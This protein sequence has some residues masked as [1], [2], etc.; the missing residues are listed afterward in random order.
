MSGLDKIGKT[1]E[2]LDYER[3][4][5]Q[6]ASE[7]VF[8]TKNLPDS[9]LERG[10]FALG[11]VAIAIVLVYIGLP[12]M[13]MAMDRQVGISLMQRVMVAGIGIIFWIGAVV[14]LR[15]AYSKWKGI[16]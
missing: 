15:I 12:S 5:A 2:Q 13:L 14:L 6:L 10:L 9:R 16:K 7:S 3:D 4:Q 11:F 1:A 8:E